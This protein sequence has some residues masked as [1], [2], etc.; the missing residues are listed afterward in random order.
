[1]HYKY[2]NTY[3]VL[4]FQNFQTHKKKHQFDPRLLT[5]AVQRFEP[6]KQLL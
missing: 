1:M 4:L 3:N 6:I 5:L 2:Y